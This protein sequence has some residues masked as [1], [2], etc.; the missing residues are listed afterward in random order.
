MFFRAFSMLL[1]AA[2]Y[3]LTAFS[4][5]CPNDCA[6]SKQGTEILQ[7]S[8]EMV[9]NESGNSGGVCCDC[10]SAFLAAALAAVSFQC[11][12][13]AFQTR[14][15]ATETFCSFIFSPSVVQHSSPR[16]QML[17][18]STLFWS[19]SCDVTS[20]SSSMAPYSLDWNHVS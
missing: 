3:P 9:S 6:S 17:S 14:S 16:P 4:S 2:R 1:A 13:C 8:L 15:M 19:M 20:H 10:G 12:I 5:F 18:V 7:Y 11:S